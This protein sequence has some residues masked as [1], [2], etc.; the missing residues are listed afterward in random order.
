[1]KRPDEGRQA[2][3]ERINR[4]ER[5]DG[6]EGAE[7]EDNWDIGRPRDRGSVHSDIWRGRAADLARSGIICIHP[8]SGWWRYL[9]RLRRWDHTL[10]YALVARLR[11]FNADIDIYTEITN[12]RRRS[13]R[14][15]SSNR[16][17]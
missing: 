3:L 1:M 11:A 6:Y 12:V 2:F 9:P 8:V 14:R 13:P 7:G 5:D 10:R 16:L 17:T 15:L 4:E